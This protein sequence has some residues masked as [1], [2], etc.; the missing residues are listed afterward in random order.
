MRASP[1]FEMTEQWILEQV[2]THKTIFQLAKQ[3]IVDGHGFPDTRG[4]INTDALYA[5]LYQLLD[6]MREAGKVTKHHG[7]GTT[8]N[9]N[10]VNGY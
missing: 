7:N 3:A 1:Y 2:Q 10:W 8:Y 6:S 9:A 4:N 5:H